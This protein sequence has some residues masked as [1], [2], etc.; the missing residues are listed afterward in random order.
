M[1]W[2]LFI[3]REHSTWEPASIRVTYLF[4]GPT[5]KPVLATAN[6]GKTGQVLEKMQVNRPEG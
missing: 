5:Q 4:C 3:F 6:T 2:S 1:F